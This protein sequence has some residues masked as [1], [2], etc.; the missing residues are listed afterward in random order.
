MNLFLCS[1]YYTIVN[2]LN[3]KTAEKNR[4]IQMVIN[5]L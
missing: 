3:D 2:F 1:K 4:P 5:L